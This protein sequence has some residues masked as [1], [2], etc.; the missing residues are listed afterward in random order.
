MEKVLPLRESK[1][2]DELER[3]KKARE[4]I[5]YLLKEYKED[6][7]LDKLKKEIGDLIDAENRKLNWKR[8][9][10]KDLVAEYGN[11]V[12]RLHY[13]EIGTYLMGRA[14]V[15]QVR[16]KDEAEFKNLGVQFWTMPDA[17]FNTWREKTVDRKLWKSIDEIVERAEEILHDFGYI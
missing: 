9:T 15:L 2:M 5:D 10:N 16:K 1:I 17:G 3:K 11:F 13:R 6:E 4:L 14:W 8:V 7:V 12:F